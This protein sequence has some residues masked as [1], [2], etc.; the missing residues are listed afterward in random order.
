MWMGDYTFVNLIGLLIQ[1]IFIQ[2]ILLFYFLGM[3]S[4]LACSNKMATANGLGLAV[5][6]VITIAGTLNFFV[7]R[8]VTGDGALSWLS[9]FG[10]DVK[11]INL[12]FLELIIFISVIA[13]FVQIV[14]I[15]IDKFSPTLYNALG[16]YLP[17]ITVNCAILGACL[18]STARQYPFIPN[19]VYLLG[20]GIGWWLAICLIAAIREK[21]T[22]SHVVH[23]LKGMGIT[24]MTTGL[25]ALGF[26]ALAGIDLDQPQTQQE[27]SFHALDVDSDQEKF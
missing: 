1:S 14:E 11:N 19:L 20:S 23:H 26:M 4:Y 8:F 5:T 13:A 25:M 22:Y 9:T 7:N 18:F 2:N 21:L 17:L 3:C 15:I 6:F 24:F 27:I 16:V 10:L 12:N